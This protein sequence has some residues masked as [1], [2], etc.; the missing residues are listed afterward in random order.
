MV[1]RTD[2][3]DVEVL[4][5]TYLFRD[6]NPA[7]L[8]SLLPFVHRQRLRRGSYFYRIGEPSEQLWVLVSGQ[9]KMLMLTPEGEETVLDVVMPGEMFGLPGLFS[10]DRRRIGESVAT[11]PCVALSIEREA[12]T[13]FLGHHPAAMGRLVTRLADLVREYA[14]A[15]AL[16]AHD[17]LR[18]RVVRR[19]LDLAA[20]HG[21]SRPEGI[22]IGARISQET[23][24][25][26]IGASR[27]KVNRA[28]T[29]LVADGHISLDAGWL[30]ILDA[31]R[32]R[33]DHPEWF[34]AEDSP[35]ISRGA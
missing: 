34:T 33:R 2:G 17:D 3:D 1:A 4:L 19:L 18:G 9:V 15:I 8:G 29:E 13:R 31:A 14:E 22:R 6:L 20:L 5:N 27:P 30:T 35:A 26:M 32:M 23:L 12:L 28:L 25:G 7:G 10:S 24:A 16:A 21:E 11:E